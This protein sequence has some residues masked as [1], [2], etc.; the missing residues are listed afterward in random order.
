MSKF[1]PFTVHVRVT[2]DRPGKRFEYI[3]DLQKL[4]ILAFDGLASISGVTVADPGGGQQSSF[5]EI[6][7]RGPALSSLARGCAVKPQMG[8]SPAQLM[9]TGFYSVSASNV[10]PHASTQRISGGTTYTGYTQHSNDSIPVAAVQTQVKAL[11]TAL[12]AALTT[13]FPANVTFKIFRIEYQ[14]IVF[15]NK[16]FHFP[17]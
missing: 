7:N 14:G 15:G 2:P 6:H 4:A 9:L 11:K 8:N 13:S 16:G 1:V 17:Q 12:A 10:Q 5:G 3:R